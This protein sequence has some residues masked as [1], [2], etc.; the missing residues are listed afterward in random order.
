MDLVTTFVRAKLV[1]LAKTDQAAGADFVMA[2]H[3]NTAD[4]GDKATKPDLVYPAAHAV[5]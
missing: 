3:G 5:R 4:I 1:H 2:G